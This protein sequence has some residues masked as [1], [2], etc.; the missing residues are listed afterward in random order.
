MPFSD[1]PKAT[2]PG[3]REAGGPGLDQLQAARELIPP[4]KATLLTLTPV[5]HQSLGGARMHMIDSNFWPSR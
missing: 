1:A 3:Y 2:L 5:N 4:H